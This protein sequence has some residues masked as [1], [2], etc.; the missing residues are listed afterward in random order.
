MKKIT[1]S[2]FFQVGSH[3]L[4]FSEISFIAWQDRDQVADTRSYSNIVILHMTYI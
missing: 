2:Y 4:M 1:V 3:F